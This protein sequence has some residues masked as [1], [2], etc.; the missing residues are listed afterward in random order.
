MSEEQTPIE[1]HV[2]G[3]DDL[4]APAEQV[5]APEPNS[6]HGSRW[7]RL[8]DW[9][10]HHKKLTIPLSILLLLL[11]LSGL[12]F[13]R[14][15]LAGTIYKKDFA[16]HVIDSTTNTAVSGAMVSA[17]GISVETD[18]SGNARL[19]L[20]VGPKQLAVNKKYYQAKSA[21]VTVPIIKKGSQTISLQATGRQVK[22]SITNL[23]DKTPLENVN[24][25]S[26]GATAKTDKTGQAIIVVPAGVTEQKATLSLNG[27]NDSEVNLKV[28][29]DKIQNN[30]LTLTPAGKVYF[31]SKLS[32]KIDV[33]KTNLD[34]TERQTVLAGTGK[35]DNHNTVLLASRDWKYLALLSKRA[36]GTPALYQINTSDDSLSTM[37]DGTADI[38]LK[39]WVDDNFVYKLSKD[40]LQLWKPGQEILNSFSAQTKKNT[41]L[42]QTTASGSNDDNYIRELISDVYAYDNQVYY[43]KNWEAGLDKAGDPAFI[44][45]QATLNAI[46]P[47]GSS[48]RALKSFGLAAGSDSTYIVLSS[49]LES[50]GVIK[51]K[52]YDG[53]DDVFYIY[54]DGQVKKDPSETTQNFFETEYPTYL[55]SPSGS[56][57]FWSESRD[58]KSTLFIGDEEGKNGKQ[59]ASL[60]DY[61]TYGWYTDNYLLASKD[62]SELYIMPKT[63]SK[64]PIKISDYHKPSDT[65]YGYGGGY[66]GL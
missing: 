41:I 46:K 58:G 51:L 35:E 2:I 14:Y 5:H 50:P 45:K 42:D 47:D 37:Y 26:A 24:I 7:S 38:S 28:S 32:G 11:I 60:S 34:G 25:K 10:T 16:V 12:P 3:D 17:G 53:N 63:G 22:L 39:G 13:T 49:F 20:K 40:N 48:K 15:A 55:E 9:Y 30:E 19:H 31:L 21:K 65:F 18:A 62:S 36:G 27:Y 8:K 44:S 52:F 6:H 1:P 4:P 33:V 29:G 43:I 57:T 23:V 64:N 61:N 56:Q 59:I 54:A 66:G